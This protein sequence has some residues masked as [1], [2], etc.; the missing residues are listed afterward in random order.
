MEHPDPRSSLAPDGTDGLNVLPPSQCNIELLDY[1]INHIFVP[2]RLPSRADGNPRLE[3]SLLRLISDLA[4]AFTSRLEPESAPRVGWDIISKML[5]ASAKLHEDELTDK[6]I[7]NAL[8]SMKPG[9][10]T[11]LNKHQ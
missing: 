3:A 4:G 8:A 10:S 2:P 5:M 9:G 6:S 1:A 11:F 7:N